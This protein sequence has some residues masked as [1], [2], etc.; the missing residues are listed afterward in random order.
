MQNT[1]KNGIF[2]GC[3]LVSDIDGT[4]VHEGEIPQR[5]LRAIEHFIENG[6]LFSIATGRSVEATRPYM[7]SSGA[8]CPAIVFNG[9]VVYDYAAETP[10][11]NKRLPESAKP[12]LTDLIERFPKIG[13]Q[14]HDVRHLYLMNRTDATD[15]H[16]AY[17]H[18]TADDITTQEAYSRPWTK[19]LFACLQKDEMARLHE[20][21]ATLHPDGCYFLKT[22]DIYFELT[23]EGVNKGEG[24]RFLATHYHIAPERV[25]AIGDYFN[26]LEMLQLAGVGAAIEN[27][28]D[29]VKHAADFVAGTCKDGAVADFIEYLENRLK[30]L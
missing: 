2:S 1:K 29:A 7:C 8:N 19:L 21:A 11:R 16:M 23:C 6:G 15:A 12:I 17:E 28:P 25:F 10:I 27:S 20:Y 26:D 24:L 4:L 14:I 13:A 18:L 9:A 3:L 22:A 30:S 5:N